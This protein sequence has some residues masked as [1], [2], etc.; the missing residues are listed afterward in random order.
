MESLSIEIHFL[1][2]FWGF[3][4]ACLLVHFPLLVWMNIECMNY[5]QWV[6]IYFFVIHA[7]KRMLWEVSIYFYR[8]V[9][10]YKG[11]DHED[12]KKG[13]KCHSLNPKVKKGT[14]EADNA[15]KL[16][17]EDRLKL[18][19]DLQPSSDEEEEEEMDV[20]GMQW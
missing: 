4:I 13:G 17:L 1:F 18:V 14:Q 15:L 12:Y 11:S 3:C 5:A 10:P 7:I 8:D 20:E 2:W 19:V 16:S 6:T 9:I